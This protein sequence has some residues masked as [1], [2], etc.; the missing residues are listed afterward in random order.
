MTYEERRARWPMTSCATSWRSWWTRRAIVATLYRY[1]D[2]LD[3]GDRDRVPRLLHVRRRV[4]GQGPGSTRPGDSRF[5]GHEQLRGYF[6]GH[7]HAP[8]AFHKH[9]TVNPLVTVRR[10]SGRRAKLLPTGRL[11]REPGRRWCWRRV[12]ISTVS[13]GATTGGW[14]IRSRRLRGGEPV[15]DFSDKYG[16]WAVVAGASEGVG[17]AVARQLGERGVNVVLVAAARP[18][19][20]EVAATVPADDPYRRTGPQR[21]RRRRGVGRGIRGSRH[22]SPRLQRRRRP[23][24]VAGFSTSRWRPGRNWSGAT[25]TPCSAPATDFGSRLAERGRGG[26]V[27][28]TSGAAW[29]GRRPPR[30][31][32]ASKA[33]DLVLG[34]AL[35]AELRP[36]GVDVL[37][38]VLRPDRHTRLPAGAARPGLPRT[39]PTPTTSPARC[40]T[41]SP[42]PDLPG[43]V[44]FRRSAS[45]GDASR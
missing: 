6:D 31:Y 40:S 12:A 38:M 13:S 30:A 2:A 14:R 35:W 24:R 41:A 34:E 19:L 21:R 5:V 11:A 10:R 17:S 37:S 3:H 44:P 16:P 45:A 32:G 42:R 22:R 4:R 15:T 36:H 18:L 9:V 39:S 27:L 1:G 26:I 33:F 7:T 8:V 20:D 29:A 43:R 23:E 25:S 28:V